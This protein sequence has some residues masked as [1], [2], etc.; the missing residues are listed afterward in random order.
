[1]SGSDQTR[2][3]ALGRVVAG[4]S[5]AAPAAAVTVTSRLALPVAAPSFAVNVSVRV[6]VLGFWLELLYVT[7]RSAVWYAAGL[8]DPVSVRVQLAAV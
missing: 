1:M 7:V 5:T 3:R 4:A 8:A 2:L 6:A